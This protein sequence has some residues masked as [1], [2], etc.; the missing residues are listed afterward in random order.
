MKDACVFVIFGA[1]GNLAQNKLLPA[2][3]H[4][5]EACRLPAEMTIVGFGRRDWTT[6]QWR[7]EVAGLLGSKVRRGLDPNV[8]SHFKERL[9]YFQGDLD[10]V[11]S[12]HRLKEELANSYHAS[13]NVAFYMAIR[14]AEFVIVSENIVAAGLHEEEAGWRRLVIEKPF[15]HDLESAEVL[16]E[17][18]H[19]H[20]SERQI[21]RID[22]YLGKGTVQNV[23]I[24]RFANIMLEPLWNRNYI[25]HVQITHSETKGINGRADYYDNAGALRDMVQSH[26][27][28]LLT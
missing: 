18:L 24:F 17:R 10:D 12:Y 27:L 21:F 9:H 25:D 15:G 13:G 14:P 5:E 8:F 6:E 16:E 3:Y 11:H 22:H 23:L 20:F 4:L 26:L 2:L 19:R 28:Q 7:N 1:T